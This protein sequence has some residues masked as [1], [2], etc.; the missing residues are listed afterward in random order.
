MHALRWLLVLPAA[1]LGGLLITFPL[2]W[3]LMASCSGGGTVTLDQGAQDGLERI[4]AFAFTPFGFVLA[5]AKTAPSQHLR[6][7][8]ILGVLLAIVFVGARVY[9]STDPK[10]LE[11]LP[12]PWEWLPLALNFAGVGAGVGLI[13]AHERSDRAKEE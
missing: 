9:V 3:V 11:Y 1:I 5:G 8:A 2:H 12:A 6:A 10:L 13:Y 4:L 7:A